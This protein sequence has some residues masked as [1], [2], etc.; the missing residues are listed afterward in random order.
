MGH[1][2]MGGLKHTEVHK[3]VTT[4]GA[5]HRTE[6][7]FFISTLGHTYYFNIWSHSQT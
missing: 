5:L 1:W 7:V 6:N 3:L 2:A 4:F